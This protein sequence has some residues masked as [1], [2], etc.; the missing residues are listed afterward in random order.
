MHVKLESEGVILN[1]GAV[2]GLSLSYTNEQLSFTVRERDHDLNIQDIMGAAITPGEYHYVVAVYD[3]DM[4]QARLYINSIEQAT[5]DFDPR[6]LA[7]N[8]DLVIG[9]ADGFDFTGDLSCLIIYDRAL[10]LE[11]MSEIRRCSIQ[12]I[13]GG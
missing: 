11:E 7:S 5:K 9:G 8:T 12:E 13:T 3:Y 4:N 2:Q 6:E 10:T 1:Y